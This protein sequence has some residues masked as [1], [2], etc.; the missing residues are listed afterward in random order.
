MIEVFGMLERNVCMVVSCL[1]KRLPFEV[2]A[3]GTFERHTASGLLCAL[4][5]CALEQEEH[6]HA[7]R[8]CEKWKL[9]SACTRSVVG[10]CAASKHATPKKSCDVPA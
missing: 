8:A 9:G 3:F 1:L 7:S 6:A 10:R 2:E 4:H 5:A